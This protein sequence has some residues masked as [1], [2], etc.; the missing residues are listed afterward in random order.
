MKY[1][2]IVVGSGLVGGAATRLAVARGLRVLCIDRKEA[3]AA[4]PC[5]AGVWRASWLAKHE[6]AL[7]EA[8]EAFALLALAPSTLSFQRR[9]KPGE[10]LELSFLHPD[11]LRVTPDLEADVISVERNAV[12]VSG[13]NRGEPLRLEAKEVYV[14]AGVWTGSL[15]PELQPTQKTGTVFWYSRETPGYAGPL[16]WTWAPYRQA[17]AFERN[18]DGAGI[19][20][21]DGT[22]ILKKNYARENEEATRERARQCGLDLPLFSRTGHRPYM[23]EGPTFGRT[24][25]GVWYGTGTAKVGTILGPSFAL[26]LISKLEGS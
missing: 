25:S 6:R 15:L 18:P 4:S 9:E 21:S 13:P 19:Y 20:F 5:A 3:G 12:M 10:T 16:A 11:N 17:F 2:L 24:E 26:Q 1:D 7:E 8:Q 22:A 14:A 23:E